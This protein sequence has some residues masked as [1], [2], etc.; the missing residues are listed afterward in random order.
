MTSLLKRAGVVFVLAA[1]FAA[2]AA[3]AQ[4]WTW[5]VDTAQS[6]LTVTVFRTGA[7]SP[8]LH[9]HFMAPKEWSGE[10]TADPARPEAARVEIRAS[11]GS[12][13]DQQTE[14]SAEDRVKVN[15]T[16]RSPEVLDASR[17][18]EILYSAGRFEPAASPPAQAG[19][20]TVLQGTLVGALTLHGRTRELRVPVLARIS[21]DTLTAEGRV[22][23]N[24]TGF[25]IRPFSSAC[26][27]VHAVAT[28]DDVDALTKRARFQLLSHI[29][30]CAGQ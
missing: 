3:Q 22:T 1:T 14:L 26:M 24:Q 18:P 4:E 23:F 16:S 15:A 29:A 2:T 20:E 30:P 27:A 21:G 11:A 19:G 8:L 5:R 10:V 9:D 7:F 28:M 6:R 12:L 13:E 25:G 17:Y